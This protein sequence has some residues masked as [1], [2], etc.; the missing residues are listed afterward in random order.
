MSEK[1]T[2]QAELPVLGGGGE[3]SLGI[4]TPFSFIQKSH[5]LS[6]FPWQTTYR[7]P[8]WYIQWA[9]CFREDSLFSTLKKNFLYI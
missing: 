6:T 9:S 1:E 7:C 8:G 4:K 5:L 3:G 2:V